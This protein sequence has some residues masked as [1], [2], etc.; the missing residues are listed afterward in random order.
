MIVISETTKIELG[1][2]VYDRKLVT[3]NGKVQLGQ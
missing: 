2:S 3:S 1:E